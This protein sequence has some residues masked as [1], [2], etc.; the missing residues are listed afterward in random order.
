MCGGR[1]PVID[2]RQLLLVIGLMVGHSALG[3]AQVTCAE[4]YR[5]AQ[6]VDESLAS[7]KPTKASIITVLKSS[8]LQRAPVPLRGPAGAGAAYLQRD[9]LGTARP[10][11]RAGR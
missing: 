8:V 4:H 6:K 3:T 10:A 9:G 5:W 7:L 1:G 11:E 2:S